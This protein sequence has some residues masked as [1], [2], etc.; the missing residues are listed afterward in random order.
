METL[1]INVYKSEKVTPDIKH[2]ERRET[3][4][5]RIPTPERLN[6]LIKQATSNNT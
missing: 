6:I 5:T 4:H 2:Q 1:N 3:I